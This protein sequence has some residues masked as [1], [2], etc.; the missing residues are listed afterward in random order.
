MTL[1]EGSQLRTGF[2][3]VINIVAMLITVVLIN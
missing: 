3:D 1:K 2:K